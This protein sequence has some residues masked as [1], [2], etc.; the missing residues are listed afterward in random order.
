[1]ALQMIKTFFTAG[2]N[3]KF[4]KYIRN[5]GLSSDNLEYLDFIPSDFCKEILESN[6]LKIDIET[7]N[8]Y[9]KN[10]DTNESV[11]EFF[12]NQQ[13]SLKGDI[14]FDFIYDGN[15]DNY[16]RWI[17]Q[18]FDNYKKNKLDVLTDKNT[19]FRFNDLLQQSG[20]KF[21]V[22]KRTAVT[23]DYFAAEEIQNQN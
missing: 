15:Y 8:I 17:I 11:F 16:F 22:A 6:D 5:F 9:H 2:K 18:G 14:K 19:K 7:G 23:D 21:K 20:Q 1:M 3:P 13:H 12:K 10:T 4:D